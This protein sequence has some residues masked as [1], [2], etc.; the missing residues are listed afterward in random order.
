M[1][2][3]NLAERQFLFHE[4]IILFVASSRLYMDLEPVAAAANE[5]IALLERGKVAL[6][7]RLSA[8]FSLSAPELQEIFLESSDADFEQRRKSLLHSIAN[9]CSSASGSICSRCNGLVVISDSGES[10]TKAI[11]EEGSTTDDPSG[12]YSEGQS[13]LLQYARPLLPSP[14][15]RG[16]SRRADYLQRLAETLL[17]ALTHHDCH[18]VEKI[19]QECPEVV[20]GL[21][22][23]DLSSLVHSIQSYKTLHLLLEEGR[24][25]PNIFD[26]YGST[27]LH[28]YVLDKDIEFVKLL[29]KHSVDCNIEDRRNQRSAVQLAALQ[30]N[31]EALYIMVT[32]SKIPVKVE[33]P[34]F[35]GNSLL[36]LVLQSEIPDVQYKSIAMFLLDRGL[37]PDAKNLHGETPLHYFCVNQSLCGISFIEP[38]FEML[39]EGLTGESVDLRDD[40]HCTPLIIACAHREWELCKILIRHGADMNIPCSM[41]S[42]LLTRGCDTSRSEVFQLDFESDCTTGDLMPRSVRKKIFPY[43]CS[44]QS[45]IDL[46]SRD[47]CMNCAALFPDT[48]SGFSLFGS[49]PKAHCRNCGRV[50]CQECLVQSD[51]PFHQLPEYLKDSCDSKDDIRVCVICH[52]ILSKDMKIVKFW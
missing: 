3:L 26:K 51:L 18:L 52:P 28:K 15:P 5:R 23:E 50:V 47:R 29:L 49:G 27:L 16:D 35:D 31:F 45:L 44:A 6:F 13:G 39:V 34:D 12:V 14:V 48:N 8:V 2:F 4:F 40:D 24:V 30:G 37:S 25:D 19:V 10:K 22:E 38:L 43:I 33:K 46:D 7:D 41:S 11:D 36:H 17:Y 32:T 21:K 20:T 42:R 9:T 1:H